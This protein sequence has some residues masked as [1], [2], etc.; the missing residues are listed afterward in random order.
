MPNLTAEESKKLIAAINRLREYKGDLIEKITAYE[1][2]IARRDKAQATY[3][4]EVNAFLRQ[5]GIEKDKLGFEIDEAVILKIPHLVKTSPKDNH[6]RCISIKMNP[7]AMLT[8]KDFIDEMQK[9]GFTAVEG[10]KNTYMT[11]DGFEFE[12]ALDNS[13][14]TAKESDAGMQGIVIKT[15]FPEKMLPNE[16]VKKSAEIG[17][18][19]LRLVENISAMVDQVWINEQIV[20]FNEWMESF[21]DCQFPESLYS[22]SIKYMR[23]QRKANNN[24]GILPILSVLGYSYG[25]IAGKI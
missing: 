8:Q 7:S 20:K 15:I 12:A 9:V 18:G 2:A 21:T 24:G 1:I 16:R 10:K 23:D 4:A 25:S 3:L 14:I 6:E 11:K 13:D 19:L 17:N 5:Q 22:L